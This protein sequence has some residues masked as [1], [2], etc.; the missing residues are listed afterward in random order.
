MNRQP[1]IIKLDQIGDV[2]AESLKQK[3]TVNC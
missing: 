2:I 3:D 1:E